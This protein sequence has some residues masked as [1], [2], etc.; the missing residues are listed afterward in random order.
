MYKTAAF[1]VD[2]FWGRPAE[3]A[4]SLGVL[5]LTWNQAFYRYGLLDF[6]K[7]EA[8]I[9]GNM[10]ALEAYRT[11]TILDYTANDDPQITALFHDLLAA[12]AI[13]EGSRKGRQSAVAAAKA[14]HLLAPGFFPL[15]D[16]E[17][18]R[19]YDCEYSEQPS[20]QYLAFTKMMQRTAHALRAV[21][22][23]EGKTLLKLIDEYNYAKFTKQWI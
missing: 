13:A 22:V 9:A 12:L 8:C 18:A 1:L 14:L 2:H 17:I 20:A 5:L 3:M 7:L 6:G 19:A 11:R 4:D 10:R 16:R 15:W 21:T 23:P